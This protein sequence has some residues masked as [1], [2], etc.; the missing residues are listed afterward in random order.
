V[1]GTHVEASQITIFGG[2]IESE[3][4]TERLAICFGTT[5]DID[6]AIRER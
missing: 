1:V 6:T 5:N 2:N 4:L 3:D